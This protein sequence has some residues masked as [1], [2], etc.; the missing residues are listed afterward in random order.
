MGLNLKG[1]KVSGVSIS[2]QHANFFVNDG[3][4][5]ASDVT[6]L[7]NFCKTKAKEKYGLELVEEIQMVGEF[8]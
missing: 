5:K 4:G 6:E 1:Q 3:T 7:I 8:Q 2:S